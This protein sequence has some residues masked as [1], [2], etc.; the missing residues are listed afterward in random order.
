[1]PLNV[2]ATGEQENTKEAQALLKK[3]A[4]DPEAKKKIQTTPALYDSLLVA[5]KR[6][7]SGEKREEGI[8]KAKQLVSD[9]YRVS[10]ELLGEDMTEAS[11]CI[12]AKEEF[13]ALIREIGKHPELHGAVVSFDLS[14]IGLLVDQMLTEQHLL[15]MARLAKENQSVLMI[16]MENSRATDTI[17]A[18][19]GKAASLFPENVG[20]TIQ[21][22]L[23][24]TP[25]DLLQLLQYP[26]KIR[27]VKGVYNEP[28]EISIPRSDRLNERFVELVTR[29]VDAEHKI[30]IA[31]HD[32]HIL[33]KLEEQ[34]YLTCDHV[35]VE[36]LYGVRPNL[37]KSLKEQGCNARVYVTYGM[38][39][40]LHFFHRL[41]EYP[42]NVYAALEDM[43]NPARVEENF[44]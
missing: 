5:A 27:I 13:C 8:E 17:L 4:R 10:L 40:H 42:P 44:Y 24:R 20:I 35:E 23:K 43:F 18:L 15:E 31:T 26:G 39:W 9:G 30:S 38:D 14:Q 32:E 41:A 34:G 19:Y 16:S 36:M 33:S 29:A 7:I 3:I 21:A 12:D 22:Y 37:L 28:A 6:Y 25:E 2:L 11:Q 1:M